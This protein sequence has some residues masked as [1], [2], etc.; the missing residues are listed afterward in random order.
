ME[1]NLC[2]FPDDA[3]HASGSCGKDHGVPK[4]D[5]VTQVYAVLGQGRFVRMI[6]PDV[7]VVLLDPGLSG[8]PGL[9]NVDLTFAGDAVDSSCFQAKVILDELK[10]TGD[11]PGQDAYNFFLLLLLLKTDPTKSKKVMRH[12]IRTVGI[13]SRNVSIFLWPVKDDFVFKTAGVHRIPCECD[14][15]YAD[16]PGIPLRQGLR[17]SSGISDCIVLTDLLWPSTA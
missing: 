17:S 15:V 5:A 11:L 9:P 2:C 4:L 10:E 6:Q 7:L 16:K 1:L 14:K 12:N 8:M 3:L 13:P